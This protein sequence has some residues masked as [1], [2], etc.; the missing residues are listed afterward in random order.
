MR[1]F[2][3]RRAA[4]RAPHTEAAQQDQYVDGKSAP[5]S[6][7]M[8]P[9]DVASREAQG[10][11]TNLPSI[12][13][14]QSSWLQL[15]AISI[16]ASVNAVGESFY[17][18]AL[19]VVACGRTALGARRRLLTATLVREPTNPHD[20]N[21]VRVDVDGMAVAHLSRDD[22]PRFHRII[23]RLANDGRPATCRAVL[24]GGWD[25]GYGDRGHLGIQILTGRRPSRWTGRAP[26][27]PFSPWHEDHVVALDRTSGDLSGLPTRPVVTL[28]DMGRR[29]VTVTAG[30][31]F[32]GGIVGRHDLVAFISRVN[33]AGLPTTAQ[34]CVVEEQLY[35]GGDRRTS[36]LELLVF[37]QV[38]LSPTRANIR[39]SGRKRLQT[40]PAATQLPAS[41]IH[42]GQSAT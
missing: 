31:R 38:E 19:E 36:D 24:T 35:N 42:R 17:Q 11:Q 9:R 6:N 41:V 20:E 4:Q 18:E 1:G 32:L 27:L 13:E 26:F 5:D 34:A 33:A 12:E 7:A 40:T 23:Q 15:P 21:A 22:A 28:T 29:S 2:L 39:F 14:G 10:R 3:S 25:G 8:L 16:G 30:E 37:L